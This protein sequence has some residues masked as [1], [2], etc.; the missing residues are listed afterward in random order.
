MKVSRSLVTELG[1]VC[2]RRKLYVNVAKSKVM[3]VAR[4]ETVDNLNITVNGRSLNILR[5]YEWT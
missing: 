5:I 1:K 3:R 4:R 2:E